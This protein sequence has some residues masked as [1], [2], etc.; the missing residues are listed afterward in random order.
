[1]PRLFHIDIGP[2][3]HQG[4]VGP[5]FPPFLRKRS[6]RDKGSS[7]IQE[8]KSPRHYPRVYPRRNDEQRQNER[9]AEETDKEKKRESGI[10]KLANSLTNPIRA[11]RPAFTWPTR[12]SNMGLDPFLGPSTNRRSFENDSGLEAHPS[13][14]PKLPRLPRLSGS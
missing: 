3:D 12:P 8:I 5:S 9:R 1:M 4:P 10:C 7:F 13:S 14:H 2:Q 6:A 11:G